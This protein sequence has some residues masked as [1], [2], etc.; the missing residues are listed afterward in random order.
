MDESRGSK[1]VLSRSDETVSSN[2]T[3]VASFTSRQTEKDV[4]HLSQM[5]GPEGTN[6]RNEF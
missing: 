6:E 4:S 2:K 5:T 1:R 3:T